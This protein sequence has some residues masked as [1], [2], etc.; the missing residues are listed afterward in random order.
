[1]GVA[2]RRGPLHRRKG[3]KGSAHSAVGR[4]V[5]RVTG[6]TPTSKSKPSTSDRKAIEDRQKQKRQ[7]EKQGDA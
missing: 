1:V 3:R 7:L 6:G 4:A 5:R 2:K